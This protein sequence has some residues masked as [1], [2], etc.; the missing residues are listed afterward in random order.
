MKSFL[1]VLILLAALA[2]AQEKGETYLEGLESWEKRVVHGRRLVLE[3]DSVARQIC[4]EPIAELNV[5]MGT[6]PTPKPVSPRVDPS[7]DESDGI[8]NSRPSSKPTSPRVT[9]DGDNE[10]DQDG[11]NEG[12]RYDG[13][14]VPTRQPTFARNEN[15]GDERENNGR[16]GPGR[17][18]LETT[19]EKNQQLCASVKEV[20]ESSESPCHDMLYEEK[21]AAC[22]DQLFAAYSCYY[23]KLCE[24]DFVCE[25]FDSAK[26]YDP[27]DVEE[28]KHF[29]KTLT[30]YDSFP[31]LDYKVCFFYGPSWGTRWSRVAGPLA[32][33]ESVHETFESDSLF[34]EVHSVSPTS[35]DCSDE[36]RRSLSDISY[37]VEVLDIPTNFVGWGPDASGQGAPDLWRTTDINDKIFSNEA[38]NFGSCSFSWLSTTGIN[39]NINDGVPLE[40][41]EAHSLFL[42]N[43]D[44]LESLEVTCGAEK[45]SF[46]ID[47]LEFCAGQ[48]FAVV[49]DK[50]KAIFPLQI[51]VIQGLPC[52]GTSYNE[53]QA[54]KITIGTT[55]S[56]TIPKPIIVTTTHTE[57][58]TKKSSFLLALT[59][60]LTILL[61]CSFMMVALLVVDKFLW[62][63][64]TASPPPQEAQGI[65][66]NHQ[67]RSALK[68][69]VHDDIA[70][71]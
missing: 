38:L 61:L 17:R 27:E 31:S 41:N 29:N 71:I 46:T 1:V 26:V 43:Y 19:F 64:D 69:P 2:A 33:G 58:K 37:D 62:S 35:T 56:D 10:G 7:N 34:F 13:G 68:N 59:I 16:S 47:A 54:P 32:Y 14:R 23:S 20:Q 9:Q 15:E 42:A 5:C 66:L 24:M 21:D 48:H 40:K 49:G 65:Q 57:K 55:M 25:N 12:G 44:G 3:D 6:S 60:G 8:S 51:M 11:D 67:D 4:S 53:V 70:A 28:T 50:E 63:D 45:T 52:S 30:F 36:S 39:Q 22:V 18:R